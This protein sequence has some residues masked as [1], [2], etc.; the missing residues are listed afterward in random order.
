METTDRFFRPPDA[1]ATQR[2]YRRIQV[3]RILAIAGNV[4]AVVIFALTFGWLWQTTQRDARFAIRD[5]KA[6][7]AVNTSREAIDRVMNAYRGGNLFRLDIEAVKKDLLSLPWVASVAIEKELPGRL[8]VHVTER[9]PVAIVDVQGQLRY[10]DADGTV[11]A[12][13]EPRYGS[14]DL[15]LVTSATGPEIASCIE[16][17]GALKDADGEVY[18][19]ISEISPADGGTWRVWDRDL[20]AQ[21]FIGEHPEE[22]WKTLYAIAAREGFGKGMIEYADLRFEDRVIVRPRRGVVPRHEAEASI[23]TR[24]NGDLSATSGRPGNA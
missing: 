16:R 24:E 12:D 18:G 21:V 8:T 13:V 7:G 14:L 23:D 9:V 17:L 1:Q 22:K 5:V 2:N 20:G 3:Q 11:F 4:V 19:R 6:T 10:A 15:P